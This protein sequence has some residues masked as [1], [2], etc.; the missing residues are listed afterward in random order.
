[1]KYVDRS[2]NILTSF[3]FLAAGADER[4]KKKRRGRCRE[5]EATSETDADV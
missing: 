4:S 5:G 2:K 3:M 1:M